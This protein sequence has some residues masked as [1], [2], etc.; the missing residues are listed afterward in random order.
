[1]SPELNLA[2]QSLLL[3]VHDGSGLRLVVVWG[4]A[5]STFRDRVSSRIRLT[6]DHHLPPA[7]P[8][9]SLNPRIKANLLAV[10]EVSAAGGRS[11]RCASA[12]PNSTVWSVVGPAGGLHLPGERCGAHDV[13]CVDPSAS[14]LVQLLARCKTCRPPLLVSP[15]V[16]PSALSSGWCLC[17][18]RILL[19]TNMCLAGGHGDQSGRRAPVIHCILPLDS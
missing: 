17:S 10:A 4:R 16:V 9:L 8:T 18:C 15:A 3:L 14:L 6:S 2:F 5:A 12:G 13:F 7:E 11:C 1:M 19:N